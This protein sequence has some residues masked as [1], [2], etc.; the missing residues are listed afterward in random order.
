MTR[1]KNVSLVPL[2]VVLVVGVLLLAL[3]GRTQIV[4]APATLRMNTTQIAAPAPMHSSSSAAESQQSL[5]ALGSSAPISGS[6]GTVQGPASQ[7]PDT[8][9]KATC[10]SVAGSGLPCVKP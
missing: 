3:L 5:K 10:P 8:S 9:G 1:T 2:W 7:A 4:L 6:T